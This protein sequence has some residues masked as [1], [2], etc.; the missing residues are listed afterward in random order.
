MPCPAFRDS[1]R[2]IRRR[3]PKG[4]GHLQLAN[5]AEHT[6]NQVPA[7]DGHAS[8]ELAS[9]SGLFEPA[10]VRA[11][12]SDIAALMV[13]SH[14][15]YMTNLITRAGWEARAADPRRHPPFV[16]APGED[17]RVAAVM[18]GVASEVVDYLLF[19]DET[20]LM[21][22]VRGA[23]GFAERFSAEGPRDK[24]GRSLHELDLDRR[25]MKYPCSYLI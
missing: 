3:G 5:K 13:F 8:R 7:L 9:Q 4:G 15:T 20:R 24:R 25:L 18:R 21:D 6:G 10:G 22:H 17:A 2:M 11:T 12:T 16:A 19:I 1:H 14:Q 23:S